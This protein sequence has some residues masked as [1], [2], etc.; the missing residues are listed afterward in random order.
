VFPA[1][2]DFIAYHGAPM[3]YL[4]TFA[5]QHKG[6]FLVSNEPEWVKDEY[7]EF[8]AKVAPADLPTWKKMTLTEKR[9]MVR[10]LLAD[11]LKLQVHEDTTEH[12]G[13]RPGGG[14]GRPEVDGVP[15]RRHADGA[16]RAGADGQGA[17]LV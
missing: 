5:Y 7:W 3:H 4:L 14:E 17:E 2:G 16:G 9:M 11:E 6:Y 10:E 8:E 15:A 12:P 13:V 1:E